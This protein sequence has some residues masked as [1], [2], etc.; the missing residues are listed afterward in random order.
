MHPDA[1]HWNERYKGEIDHYLRRGPFPLV[2]KHAELLPTQGVVLETACGVSP[3]SRF[4]VER[5]LSLIGLDIC[6]PAL[7][8][9]KQ[10]EPRLACAIMDLMDAWLPP[11]H[12]EAIFN[13]YFLSRPLLERYRT[14][15]KP[16]G[17]LFCEIFVWQEG[18]DLSQDKYLQPG[19]LESKFADW[20]TIDRAEIKKRRRTPSAP[21]RK[22]IQLV[23]Q[24]PLE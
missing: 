22:A 16:G 24:K 1:R 12:F 2:R 3:L 13:F 9:A 4:L 11:E 14:A 20:K 7:L 10:R 5:G 17:L 23:V 8:A 21:D 18:V 15:I 19:E 6:M